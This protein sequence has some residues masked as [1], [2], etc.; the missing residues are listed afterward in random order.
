MGILSV[1]NICLI[2]F[3]IQRVRGPLWNSTT[4]HL[5]GFLHTLCPEFV[6]F[7]FYFF[8]F[9]FAINFTANC[10]TFST[11]DERREI[12]GERHNKSQSAEMKIN[13]YLTQW[14]LKSSLKTH[15]NVFEM[16]KRATF[17]PH[18]LRAPV[19]TYLLLTLEIM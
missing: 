11:E 2:H 17:C 18:F 1:V 5:A 12:R 3:L 16:K 14:S 7:Y 6:S 19:R 4:S 8:S 13:D 10:A 15:R 9:F